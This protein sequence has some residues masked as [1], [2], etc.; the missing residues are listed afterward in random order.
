MHKGAKNNKNRLFNFEKTHSNTISFLK[1]FIHT[2]NLCCIQLRVFK[3]FGEEI[4]KN[5]I[6]LL[7]KLPFE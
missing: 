5:S 3:E 4:Y 6:R 7:V 2:T 1:F